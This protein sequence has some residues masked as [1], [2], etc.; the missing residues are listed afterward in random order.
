MTIEDV[1]VRFMGLSWDAA[2]RIVKR[3]LRRDYGQIDLHRGE[4]LVHR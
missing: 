1:D 3:R 2:K 4:A